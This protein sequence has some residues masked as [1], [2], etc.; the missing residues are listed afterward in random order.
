MRWAK[1]SSCVQFSY[2]AY[3]LSRRPQVNRISTIHHDEL[4]VMKN[5]YLNDPNFASIWNE[6]NK[7]GSHKG[8]CLS[9]WYLWSQNRIFVTQDL[10]LKVIEKCHSHAFLGHQCLSPTLSQLERYFYLPQMHKDVYRHITSC[11]ICQKAKYDLGL[12]QPLPIQEAP[13]EHIAMDFVT[14]FSKSPQGH[15]L[16]WIV[17]D[18]SSKQAHFI[19]CKK[20]LKVIEAVTCCDTFNQVY[21][22][23]S[24]HSHVYCFQQRYQVQ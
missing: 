17:I 14:R 12:L 8:Y 2:S 23:S 15:D 9:E 3:S 4:A 5:Q 7:G 16:I 18:R 24:W 6:L 22:S 1:L 11:L 13:W 10:R 21:I 19:P 20:T